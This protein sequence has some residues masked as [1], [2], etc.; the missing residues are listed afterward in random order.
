MLTVTMAIS[1]MPQLGLIYILFMQTIF[2]TEALT[3]GD[4]L[5]LF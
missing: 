1:S 2:L 5:L 3:L 4:L